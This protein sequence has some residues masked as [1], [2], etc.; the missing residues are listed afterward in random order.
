MITLAH[1]LHNHNKNHNAIKGNLN[2]GGQVNPKK[3]IQH[4]KVV[5]MKLR[6]HAGPQ[7]ATSRG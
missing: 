4:V 1:T 5:I 3:V 7:T 6:L 2:F